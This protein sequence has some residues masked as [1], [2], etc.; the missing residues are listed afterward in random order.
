[1]PLYEYKCDKC[2]RKLTLLI[3]VTADKPK[4]V[5]P[6]CGSRKLTKLISRIAPIGRGDEF[7]DDLGDGDLEGGDELGD[8]Y[9]GGMDEDFE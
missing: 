7:D 2:G 3:G 5:C 1:M 8:E 9:G 6:R 4:Q